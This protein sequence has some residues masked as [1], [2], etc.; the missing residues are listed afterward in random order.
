MN[1]CRHVFGTLD[2]GIFPLDVM[3]HAMRAGD[4]EPVVDEDGAWKLMEGRAILRHVTSTMPRIRFSSLVGTRPPPDDAIAAALACLMQDGLTVRTTAV[5]VETQVDALMRIATV[6]GSTK[7]EPG[8]VRLMHA[9]TPWSP[10]RT[11]ILGQNGERLKA[12]CDGDGIEHLPICVHVVWQS[13][14]EPPRFEPVLGLEIEP[15]QT[16]VTPQWTPDPME[17]IRVLRSAADGFNR[18][19]HP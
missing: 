16:I 12:P 15:F 7:A 14:I 2:D 3:V 9:P 13:R 1:P 4:Y 6:T 11:E 5:D 19:T 10:I 8:R 17:A 18:E